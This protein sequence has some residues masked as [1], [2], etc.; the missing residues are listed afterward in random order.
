MMP[1]NAPGLLPKGLIAANAHQVFQQF[2]H[3]DGSGVKRNW[4]LLLATEF[5]AYCL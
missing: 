3:S 4:S 1:S 2:R 5:G